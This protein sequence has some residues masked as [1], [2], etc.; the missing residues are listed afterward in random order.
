MSFNPIN[1]HVEQALARLITQFRD[2]GNIRALITAFV[3]PIQELEDATATLNTDRLLA[4][5]LGI[6]LDLIGTIVGLARTAGDSDDTYRMK[7]YAQIKVN[8]SEGQPEQVIQTYQLFTNALLVLLFEDYPGEI[9]IESD[10]FPPDQA[11]VDLLIKILQ[12]VLPA[13][14]RA[15]GIVAFDPTEAFAYD[16]PLPGL[17]YGTVGDPT[18]GGKYPHLFTRGGFFEYAGNDPTGEGYGSVNDPLVGGRY[19][20]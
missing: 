17:G 3:T 18:A 13:G 5:A 7:L 1:N 8:T 2:S 9:M 12:E 15:S 10:Y 19:E 6:Q 14:V 16:G 4:T 11:T 20:T